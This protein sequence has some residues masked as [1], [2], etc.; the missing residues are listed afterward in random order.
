M[1]VNRIFKTPAG[2][3]SVLITLDI[4]EDPKNPPL[5]NVVPPCPDLLKAILYNVAYNLNKEA[6]EG[7]TYWARLHIKG[8][9]GAACY[10]ETLKEK[11]EHLAI[12]TDD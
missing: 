5:R 4:P 12:W 2:E 1:L 9:K 8:E 11:P 6:E 7:K 10:L 3:K